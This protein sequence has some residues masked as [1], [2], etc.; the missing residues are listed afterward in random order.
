MPI[1]KPIR[2]VHPRACGERPK[3]SSGPMPASGSSPRLRGT[4]HCRYQLALGDRFIPAP[5]GNAALQR[6]GPA[7]RPVHPRA[8]GERDLAGVQQLVGIGSSP[9]LRGTH[10]SHTARDTN[11]RFIP[12]PAGNALHVAFPSMRLYG[13]SPR[14][15]GTHRLG[16]HHVP[17][18]RF[19]PAPAGNAFTR[20]PNVRSNAVHPRACGERCASISAWSTACGSSPRLRGTLEAHSGPWLGSRFIPAPAGNAPLSLC[21]IR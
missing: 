10:D 9:R 4:L 12:A 19:I 13:S 7:L 1:R 8:C 11:G 15:R 16:P 14:L 3:P 18:H 17:G 6:A 5:A 2:A 20:L 21:R